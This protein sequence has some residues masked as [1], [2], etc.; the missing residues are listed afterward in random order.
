MLIAA[1]L[2]LRPLAGE[3]TP[4]GAE[5]REIVGDACNLLRLALANIVEVTRNLPDFP[6]GSGGHAGNGARREALPDR[7]MSPRIA[8]DVVGVASGLASQQCA[9]TQG[10]SSPVETSP[11]VTPRLTEEQLD[12]LRRCANGNTLRFESSEIVDALVAS[13][14]AKEGVGRVVTVTPTGHQ[15]LANEANLRGSVTIP[16]S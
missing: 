7:R 1:Q 16:R 15:Y 12:R 4:T 14:Y 2:S 3:S 8:P 13:G 11:Q 6:L 9:L 10:L 5:A